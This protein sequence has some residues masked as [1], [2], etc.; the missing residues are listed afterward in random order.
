MNI[1]HN[2][3]NEIRHGNYNTI[4]TYFLSNKTNLSSVLFHIY[5]IVDVL[6]NLTD[7]ERLDISHNKISTFIYESNISFPQNLTHL[8]ASNNSIYEFPSVVFS[9]LTA[10]KLID[11]RNNIIDTVEFDILNSIKTGVELFISGKY[12]GCP[13]FEI[14]WFQR[15]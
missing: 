11:V 5:T 13:Y 6:V 7:L 12:Q 14:A 4:N 9:N 15:A 10:I 8:Y 3:I 1:S 2:H